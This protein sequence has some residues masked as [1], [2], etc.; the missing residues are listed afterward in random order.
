MNDLKT[1]NEALYADLWWRREENRNKYLKPTSFIYEEY[2]LPP[3]EYKPVVEL[4][5]P[6]GDK[7]YEEENTIAFYDAFKDLDMSIAID[8][9]F[10]VMLSHTY[11]YEYIQ[12]R[13]YVPRKKTSETIDDFNDRLDNYIADHYFWYQ[14]R[15]RHALSGFWW[16]G[17]V[18]YDENLVDPF[19][20]TKKLVSFTDSDLKNALVE[21]TI[22]TKYPDLA[23]ALIDQILEID[24]EEIPV[25][26]REFNRDLA[27]LIN[28]EASTRLFNM[29]T[30][31]DFVEIIR[32][33]TN[34]LMQR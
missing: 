14:R 1:F 11:Y 5:N 31:S 18:T 29:L 34:I 12:D 30:Y 8:R 21:N 19:E 9:K 22:Y 23:K 25:G 17:H 10:W 6:D 26:K 3:E 20:Y 32:E 2:N 33:I 28:L 27:A 7:D 4:L 15:S 16:R 24:Y 13:I